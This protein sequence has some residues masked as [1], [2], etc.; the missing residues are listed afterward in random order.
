VGCPGPGGS[1]NTEPVLHP[2]HCQHHL[3]PGSHPKQA[4]VEAHLSS[5]NHCL[6]A[7]HDALC[8]KEL[9]AA[10]KAN[11]KPVAPGFSWDLKNARTMLQLL[12]VPMLQMP[13]GACQQDALHL[14]ARV[15]SSS[16]SSR[17]GVCAVTHPSSSSRT[18]HA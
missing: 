4:R 13:G 7:P 8:R 11:R 17:K 15:L 10:Y 2:L 12:R 6:L 14:L 16:S 5:T 1:S 18:A 3:A 9:H